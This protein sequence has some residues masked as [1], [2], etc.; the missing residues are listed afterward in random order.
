LKT[1]IGG[2]Y[3]DG[4]NEEWE[5]RTSEDGWYTCKEQVDAEI[6]SRLVRLELKLDKILSL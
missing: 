6:L 3:Y 2:Y 5:V 4:E 1:E